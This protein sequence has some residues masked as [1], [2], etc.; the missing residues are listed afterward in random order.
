MDDLLAKRVLG[1]AAQAA[2]TPFSYATGH[3][4]AQR[5]IGDWVLAEVGLDPA[6]AW[7]GRYQ[8]GLGCQ[9]LLRS[10]G[11][12]VAVLAEALEGVGLV[13]TETPA[14]GDVGAVMMQSEYRIEPVGALM[15]PDGW[16]SLTGRGIRSTQAD[17]FVAAWS[18]PR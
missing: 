4:C 15:G 2:R 11:G 5:F 8:T 7:R 6:K 12:L 3:D 13:R 17:R 18:V 10:S 9:R 16:L 1:H 14:L